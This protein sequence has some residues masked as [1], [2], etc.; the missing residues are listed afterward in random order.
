MR[1]PPR[2]PC[3]V[4][5][6]IGLCAPPFYASSTDTSRAAK[7]SPPPRVAAAFIC[8]VNSSAPRALY[9]ATV[10]PLPSPVSFLPACAHPV[11]SEGGAFFSPVK[12]KQ[13]L[14]F[15]ASKGPVVTC[16]SC[17]GGGCVVS[18]PCLFRCFLQGAAVALGPPVAPVIY[19]LVFKH[20]GEGGSP[21]PSPITEPFF[22]NE[23]GEGASVYYSVG[24]CGRRQTLPSGHR[25]TEEIGITFQAAPSPFVLVDDLRAARMHHF[26]CQPLCGHTHTHTRHR[27][28]SGGVRDAVC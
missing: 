27:R 4:Q 19:Y 3:T 5:L 11:V 15:P 1:C 23:R 28:G 14:P 25:G 17:L 9:P 10:P 7:D 2:L 16:H 12:L 24:G 26:H 20:L 22:N 6:G 13:V 21:P 18:P 8:T